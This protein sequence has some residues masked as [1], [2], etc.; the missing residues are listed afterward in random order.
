MLAFAKST[1]TPRALS[2]TALALS[3]VIMMTLGGPFYYLA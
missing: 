1:V 2:L 3:F